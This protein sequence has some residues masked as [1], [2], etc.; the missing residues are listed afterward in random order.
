MHSDSA[1]PDPG[2]TAASTLHRA[3]RHGPIDYE[4]AASLVVSLCET[5]SRAHENGLAYGG[6]S[7]ACVT[8]NKELDL[9]ITIEALQGPLEDID[10]E[11]KNYIAPEVLAGDPCTPRSDV[12]SLA[13]ILY[14][15]ISGS[16][17]T[18]D[19]PPPP[20]SISRTP[21][22]LDAIIKRAICVAPDDRIPSAKKLANDLRQTAQTRPIIKAPEA[23]ITPIRKSHQMAATPAQHRTRTSALIPWGIVIKSALALILLSLVAKLASQFGSDPEDQPSTQSQTRSQRPDQ[24]RELPKRSDPFARN[25]APRKS[26]PAQSTAARSKPAPRERLKESLSRLKSALASGDR[27][28]LPPEAVRRNDSAYALWERTMTWKE[29]KAFAEAHGAHLAILKE[30]KDREWA[31][32]RFDM[33][34][35]AWLGAGKGANDRWSWIDGTTLPAGRSVGK[36]E[37]WHLALTEKAILMPANPE[38]KCDVLL[39]WRDDGKNPG[40]EKE[41]LRRVKTLALSGSRKGLLQGEGLPLGTRT[42][43]SSHFYPVRTSMISWG[44]ALDFAATHGAYLA[45]PSNAEEHKWI[46]S[47]FWEFLGTGQGLWIGGFRGGPEQ[48][49]EW[50]SGEAWHS[51]GL[52]QGGNPHPL[53]DRVLLQGGGEPGDGRWTMAEGSRRKAPG[54]LLEWSAPGDRGRTQNVRRFDSKTWLAAITRKAQQVVGSDLRSFAWSKRKL[55]EQYERELTKHIREGKSAFRSIIQRPGQ[56]QADL[57]GKIAQLET[58][59]LSLAEAAANDQLLPS[60]PAEGEVLQTTHKQA[61]AALGALE[62]K[63]D[64]KIKA[65]QEGYRTQVETKASALLEEGHLEKAS[66]LRNVL[67]PLKPDLKAFLRLLYPENTDRAKLP[68]EPRKEPSEDTS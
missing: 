32:D 25:P 2:A 3:M 27:S 10:D 56:D 63:H 68:W 51:A 36:P 45:V 16:P 19:S 43:E 11:A 33:R 17:P 55:I 30:R 28:E 39:E 31:R 52:V 49:W 35:P 67:R 61:V 9:T 22:V 54:L 24:P 4:Q 62:E 58:L 50:I 12:Y 20:S 21:L 40:T 37:D 66:E 15:L 42:F 64:R 5:V 46:C 38:R 7:P 14:R 60:A 53:F 13:R 8:I 1:H 41:Q 44:E 34:Y 26:V 59:E 47:N 57:R 6:L 23:P 48:P 65:L 18:G 29:A